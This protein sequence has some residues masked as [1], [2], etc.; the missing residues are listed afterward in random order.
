[1]NR[2][3]FVRDVLHG[4]DKSLPTTL[5]RGLLT[6]LAGL[7]QIGLE[8]YL[9]PYRTGVRKQARLPVPVVAIGNLSSGGTGKTPMAALVAAHLQSTG[10]NV[11]LLSRGHGG[12]SESKRTARLVSDGKTVLLR[13]TEAGDEPVLLAES[14][15]GVPVIVGRD[16]RVSGKSAC[17]TF[18]PDII[19]CD[20]ALQFW[21]LHRDLNIVLLDARRPWDNGYVLPRG[22][23]REPPR[24][25]ARA[26]VV[27]L[28]RADRASREHIERSRRQIAR[29]AP[30]VPVFCA[31]HAPQNWVS[32]GEKETGDVLPLSHLRN[33]KAFVFS[34]IADHAA[35]VETVRAQGVAVTGER[36]FADH[37]A[38][39]PEEINALAASARASGA[40]ALVTTEKDAVKVGPLLAAL[41]DKNAAPLPAYALR[42]GMQVENESAFFAAV[43]AALPARQN[44]AA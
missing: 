22:L 42:V 31:T 3:A 44:G 5:L 23:L 14:L 16:R 25:I 37:H 36:G 21:Q 39:A 4:G 26:G 10:R 7:H 28:T 9:L 30:S 32:V 33:E 35:F 40:D 34:G 38:Y 24:H 2:D 6:P 18:A 13:P 11:V 27:V 17:E 20:D 12:Q 15:P 19:L 8:A 43:E 1:M 29:Y 41:R